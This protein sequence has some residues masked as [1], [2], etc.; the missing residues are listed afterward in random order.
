MLQLSESNEDL[1]MPKWLP[2]HAAYYIA[3]LT[4]MLEQALKVVSEF[5]K[6]GEE[7]DKRVRTWTES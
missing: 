7:Q 6:G 2:V 4:E 5:A 3:H 1:K